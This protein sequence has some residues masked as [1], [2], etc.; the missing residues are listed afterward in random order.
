MPSRSVKRKVVEENG[1]R[2]AKKRAVDGGKRKQEGSRSAQWLDDTKPFDVDASREERLH[3]E[4]VQFIGYIAPSKQ[5]R[6][7]RSMLVARIE[8]LL[9]SRW[10]DAQVTVFGSNATGLELTGGDID[11]VVAFDEAH[12]FFYPQNKKRRLGAIGRLLQ[13]S[14][15]TT[16]VTRIFGA[17]VPIVKFVTTEDLGEISFDISI[18]NEDDSG[19]RAIPL[20]KQFLIDMPPLR[21]LIL[22]VKAFLSLLDLN[23]ASHSTLSSYAITLMCISLLQ[24]NPARRPQKEI[25]DPFNEKFLGSLLMDFF[26]HYGHDF[27][28]A[29]HYI[30][31]SD[32]GI[33]T[34]KSKNWEAKPGNPAAL[35]VQCI[36]NPEK[37]ITCGCGKLP[38]IVK[39]FKEAYHSLQSTSLYN[40]SLLSYIYDISPEDD[41]RRRMLNEAVDSGSFARSVALCNVGVGTG[42]VSGGVPLS[43][44]NGA[45][46]GKI[47]P[48]N[49]SRPSLRLGPGPLRGSRAD[50]G[51]R[52]TNRNWTGMPQNVQQLPVPRWQDSQ[53]QQR[54]N[55]QVPSGE[56]SFQVQPDVFLQS[57]MNHGMF[58]GHGAMYTG[59]FQQQ[60]LHSSQQ[61]PNMEYFPNS[62]NNSFT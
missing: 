42:P 56:F 32:R 41:E 54:S 11:L 30:S 52:N 55:L 1:A 60:N 23:D 24:R 3:D 47:N 48:Q 43:T 25:D 44:R 12:E 9:K 46:R 50:H 62:Y 17:R 2:P 40:A 15:M 4:L 38:V 13:R 18:R 51:Q 45:R 20:I 33:F 37:N 22:A 57:V 36:L 29:T 61:L 7:A 28:Y 21:T 26:R 6:E 10:P 49:G 39:A 31:V 34:K 8:D 27:S 53:N 16:S 58:Q 14:G 19:P 35:A 59:H 5:E